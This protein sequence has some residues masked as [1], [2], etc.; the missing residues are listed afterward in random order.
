MY[1]AVHWTTT[2]KYNEWTNQIQ[3]SIKNISNGLSDENTS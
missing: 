2:E 1:H 3:G